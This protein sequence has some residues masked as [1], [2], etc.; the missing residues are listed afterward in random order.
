MH[1]KCHSLSTTCIIPVI[2]VLALTIT[3][4]CEQQSQSPKSNRSVLDASLIREHVYNDSIIQEWVLSDQRSVVSMQGQQ[5]KFRF[6]QEFTH[7]E[8]YPRS[9]SSEYPAN[10]GSQ[11]NLYPL[12]SA[13]SEELLIQPWAVISKGKGGIE[14]SVK[15][16]LSPPKEDEGVLI[17]IGLNGEE[18]RRSA[19]GDIIITYPDGTEVI[20]KPDGSV[21]ITGPN[22]KVIFIDSDG[23]IS[24]FPDDDT[25]IT[26]FPDG[27]EERIDEDG[28]LTTTLPDGTV[29]FETAD[30]GYTETRYPGGVIRKTYDDDTVVTTVLDTLVITLDPFGHTQTEVD[31]DGDVST[32]AEGHTFVVG[33]DGTTAEI[34]LDG[35]I[36][37]TDLDGNQ[38]V[39][40]APE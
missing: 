39:I 9:Q 40:P 29:I 24:I 21:E 17:A 6:S 19:D 14:V 25:S 3:S 10:S 1:K 18:I 34:D 20:K 28:N 12:G 5:Y 7:V 31:P 4:C 16:A 37:I 27:R 38:Q 8:R 36:T 35:N 2:V 15:T 30:G 22:G 26:Y 32:T 13:K 23:A 33:Q 11:L